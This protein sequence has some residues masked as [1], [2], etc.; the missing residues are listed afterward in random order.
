LQLLFKIK[1]RARIT[2]GEWNR[3]YLLLELRSLYAGRCFI[4]RSTHFGKRFSVVFD[5]SASTFTTGRNL[6][7]RDDCII[8]CGNGGKIAIGDNV[9]FNNNCSINCL[10][11]ITIGNDNQFGENVRIYDANHRFRDSS[12]LISEQGYSEGK[13]TIGNNCWISSNVI[14]LKD[15]TIGDNVVIGADCVIHKSI[16]SNSLVINRQDIEIRPL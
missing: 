6:N 12:K 15:V 1:R 7:L 8:R 3:R 5:A 11:E 4:D 14:I 16:P 10:K 2:L 13:I 9:F